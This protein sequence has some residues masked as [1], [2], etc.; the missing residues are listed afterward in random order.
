MSD[1]VI[2]T[3]VLLVASAAHPLS[4]FD[5]THVP[6]AEQQ[7]VFDWLVDFR[8]DA[9]RRLVL[10]DLFCIYEEYRH[11]L[12]EQDYGLHVI[13]EKM[14][15]LLRVV[16]LAWDDDG[17][18]RVPKAFARFDPS[19]RKLLAAALCDPSTIAIV[20]AT[21]TDW[22]EVEGALDAA[23]V[24][25]LHLLEAWLRASRAELGQKILPH[26]EHAP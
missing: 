21:D 13:H 20:N 25:V 14:Q 24:S 1:L 8:T 9:A 26:E 17:H 3:N 5:D 18:A 19:D 2:D 23:G 7:V 22:L 15:T 16:T 4:P 6:I 12:T 11:K 10:D